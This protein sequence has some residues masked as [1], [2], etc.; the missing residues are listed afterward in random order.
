MP[1]KAKIF[2][3][4]PDMVGDAWPACGTWLLRGLQ[5]A[6]DVP[7]LDT[8]D[9]C[10][11]GRKQLWIMGDIERSECLGAAVTQI[12]VEGDARFVDVIVLAGK[13]LRMWAR[14]LADDLVAFA[15]AEGALSVRAAGRE[16]WGRLFGDV[17]PVGSANGRTIFERAI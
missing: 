13:D 4:P 5:A 7:V 11:E 10:R 17:R 12:T 15:K 14:G 3:C 2:C 8:I 1:S 16:E 9:A 6:G